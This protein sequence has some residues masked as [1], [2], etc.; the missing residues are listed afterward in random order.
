MSPRDPRKI[1]TPVARS[2]LSLHSKRILRAF[3]GLTSAELASVC[4]RARLA[5][6][7]P[8]RFLVSLL[9]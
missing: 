9:P 1:R 6:R 7:S 2:H 8:A 3:R 4:H 5:H